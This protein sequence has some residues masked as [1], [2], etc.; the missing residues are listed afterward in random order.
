MLLTILLLLLFS[1]LVVSDSFCNPMDCGLAGSSVRGISQARILEWVAV[2]FLQGL[3]LTQGSNPCL[4]H[5]RQILYL[6]ATGEPGNYWHSI[7]IVL[8]I[9]SNIE[10][11]WSIQRMCVACIQIL[12]HFVGHPWWPRQERICLQCRVLRFDPWVRKITW[13]K[14]MA[15]CSSILSW[16]IPWTDEPGM[17]QS[18]GVPKSRKWLSN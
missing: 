9:I 12:C 13:R 11:I 17:L 7:Y 16:K 2:F 3:F 5:C 15:T 14:K 10:M 18:N 6:W 8:G 4:L 1:H